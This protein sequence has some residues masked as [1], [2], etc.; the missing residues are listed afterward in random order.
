MMHEQ[1]VKNYRAGQ[2]THRVM[3]DSTAFATTDTGLAL[4]AVDG[5][6][7]FRFLDAQLM[8]A[9]RDEPGFAA[10]P[11]ALADAKGRVIATLHIWR[12]ETGWRIALPA[13]EAGWLKDHL[14]RFVFR[15]KVGIERKHDV[16]LL[17]LF[18]ANAGA[19]FTKLNLSAPAHNQTAQTGASSVIGLADNRWLVAG[20]QTELDIV[21]DRLVDETRAADARHWTRARL[22]AGEVE[23][24]AETRGRFLPQMLKLDT[25]NSISFNK[26]CYPG[27]EVIARTRNLGRIK[28][29]MTLLQQNKRLEAGT[30]HEVEGTHIEVLDSVPFEGGALVQ[31]VAPLPLPTT[32]KPL[33]Y[34]ASSNSA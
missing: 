34:S 16:T 29:A 18:G 4:L 13:D 26:G 27:Q 3:N 6:D 32:L 5:E 28:R 14:T 22:L 9:L 8:T 23:I 7:A 17:G 25:L 33:V 11:A 19:T 30:S 12:S 15:S 24:R 1:G 21:T 10:G 20:S 2:T 31:A